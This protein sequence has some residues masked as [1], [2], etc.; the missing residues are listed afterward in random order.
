MP[1]SQEQQAQIAEWMR[2]RGGA[3]ICPQC[4]HN[5]NRVD[6]DLMCISPL[7]V[8]SD[9]VYKADP[10]RAALMLAVTCNWCAHTRL[11]S[12]ALMGILPSS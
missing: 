3:L 2:T 11:F 4:A 1:L 12:A 7:E 8:A 5:D 6:P 9:G 10:N